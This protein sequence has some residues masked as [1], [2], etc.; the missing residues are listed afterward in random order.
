MPTLT[1]ERVKN[2]SELA[3]SCQLSLANGYDY[4]Y[5]F[6]NIYFTLKYGQEILVF[7]NVDFKLFVQ[8]YGG[9]TARGCSSG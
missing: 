3:C 1:S 5:V 7:V 6:K 9:L 2:D 8:I 4:G